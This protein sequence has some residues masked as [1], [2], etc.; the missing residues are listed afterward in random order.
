MKTQVALSDEKTQVPPYVKT[1]VTPRC[2]DTDVPS[3]VKTQ[4]PLSDVKTQV[5][6]DVKAQ[7][8][9][10]CEDT[11]VSQMGRHRFTPDV[12]T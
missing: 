7:V 11:G 2:E 3:D 12:K 8:L 10:T 9:P 6:P 4:V 5:P 1:Q